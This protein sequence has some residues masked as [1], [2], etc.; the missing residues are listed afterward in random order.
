M[1]RWLLA[2]LPTY[3]TSRFPLSW[4]GYMHLYLKRLDITDKG[5]FGHL[6]CGTF[7]CVTLERDDKL[8][9]EGTYKITRYH[10]PRLNRTVLLLHDV[11][12]RSMIEIHNANYESQLEGCIAVGKRRTENAIENSVMTLE[13]LL[14]VL[15]DAVDMDITIK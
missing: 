12:N 5:C 15:K 9:P 13:A 2:S 3:F 4:T 1:F 8:I 11:P 6:V 14:L 10:S 7:D